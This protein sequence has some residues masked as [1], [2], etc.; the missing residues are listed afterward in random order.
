MCL[1]YTARKEFAW[2]SLEPLNPGKAG[3]SSFWMLNSWLCW[4]MGL[5]PIPGFRSEPANISLVFFT[6]YRWKQ[7]NRNNHKQNCKSVLQLPNWPWGPPAELG[8]LVNWGKS[9]LMSKGEM[10]LEFT[11]FNIPIPIELRLFTP[12]TWLW[13]RGP[14]AVWYEFPN[15]GITC[16]FPESTKCHSHR[17]I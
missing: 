15:I 4:T 11:S 16:G 12:G 1:H 6:Y 5:P 2:M 9:L 10:S 7:R 13:E 8:R 14:T 17:Q 3:K